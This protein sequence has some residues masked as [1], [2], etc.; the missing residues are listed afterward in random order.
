MAAD[1]PLRVII[2]DDD[3][4]V[5][6]VLRAVLRASGVAV[7]AEAENG[8]EAVE[9][10]L[11]YR[12]DVMVMDVI[13]PVLDGILATRRILEANP[14]QVVV[15]LTSAGEDE[16]EPL[17]LQAGA[18][19]LLSKDVDI[20]TLTRTLKGVMG[21]EG[22]VSRAMTMRLIERFREAADSSSGLRPIYNPLTAREWEVIDLLQLDESPGRVA[23]ILVISPET[24][25]SYIK[26]IT[27]KL[28]VHSRADAGRRR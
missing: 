7:V 18:V 14:D 28:S 27:R 4:Y 13:M 22:A 2:A 25:R 11:Q 17:A 20:N 12:P 3:P 1:E 5:R 9:L 8:R 16:F 24:V 23:E 15:A 10:G 6:C 26:N 21:G 19:G